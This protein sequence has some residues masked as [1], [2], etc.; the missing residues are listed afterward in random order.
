MRMKFLGLF[1]L[2][3]L[4]G[5]L[6]GCQLFSSDNKTET[7]ASTEGTAPNT[8]TA[9]TTMQTSAPPITTPSM[10]SNPPE[11]CT[12]KLVGLKLTA[13]DNPSIAKDLAFAVDEATLTATLTLNYQ[14][15]ADLATLSSAVLTAELENATAVFTA[16]NADGGVNLMENAVCIITDSNGMG[17]A[18]TLTVDR[19]V[20]QIPIV[21]ITLADGVK[22]DEIDRDVNTDMIFSLDASD[23]SE[24]D[25]LDPVTGR[26]RGRGNSTW[27]WDKKP[28]KIKLDQKASLLGLSENRDWVLLANYADKSLIRNTLAFEL[29]RVL[30]NIFWSPHQIPVDLFVNGEYR[31][32]YSLGEQ[33]EVAE[34]RVD[35]FEGSDPDVDYLIEI[36]GSES[37]DVNGKDYFHTEGRLVRYAAFVCPEGDHITN[38]QVEF[39]TDYFQKAE[40][41]ILSKTN[42]EDYID[43]DSFVDWI[44]LQE[45]SYNMD[46]CFRR[47][48]YM[49]KE[50]GGKI[51]M[52]PIWDF[53]LAF[54]NFSRDNENYDD[55]V[56]FGNSDDDAYV[57][58]N[59]CTYLLRDPAFCQRLYARWEEIRDELLGEAERVISTYSA[60]LDGSQQENFDVW[61][62]WGIRAG[63]QSKWCMKASSYEKQ[64]QYLRD[65]L[66]NRAAW[67]NE[68][69]PRGS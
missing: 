58:Y 6:L 24:Y 25:S 49:V 40:N 12:G 22:V 20:Y 66:Q 56:T 26:I 1:A 45:L 38:A 11:D 47:S 61:E 31:G 36:G 52:G 2:L 9:V 62:I 60:L 43:V 35:L 37:G 29:G 23:T 18:Y 41:A 32:V 17:K 15:Y 27:E 65:F 59:W 46:S 28:Y 30:D 64:I 5:L 8:T 19:T 4:T 53:D 50:K 7:S 68:N 13:A 48:C 69:L 3:L 57:K 42:Y 33:I 16:L 44:I 14:Q 21:N 55:L 34:G 67:M 51:K 54:G 39:I 10:P 63:Y